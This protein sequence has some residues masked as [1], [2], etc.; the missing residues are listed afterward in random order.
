MSKYS[1]IKFPFYGLKNKPY[2]IQFELDKIFLQISERDNHIKVLDDKSIE[3]DYFTRLVKMDEEKYTRVKFDI[4]C[5]N[6]GDIIRNNIKWGLDSSAIIFDF[7]KKEKFSLTCRK[8]KKITNNYVWV[9]KISYPFYISNIKKAE[10]KDQ[11]YLSLVNIDRKWYPYQ[12]SYSE[13][14]RKVIYL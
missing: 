12:F 8:I 1:K 10:N 7:S 14:N 4:T 5:L 2:N 13:H 11:I 9:N 6:I 3:G